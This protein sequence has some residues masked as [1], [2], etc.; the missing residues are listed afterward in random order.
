M[1]LSDLLT[2]WKYAE[3]GGRAEKEGARGLD[4]SVE[5]SVKFKNLVLFSILLF[6]SCL[7]TLWS[8]F[9]T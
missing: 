3:K 5:K 9:Q 8:W 7:D 2:R 6:R 4:V 1:K